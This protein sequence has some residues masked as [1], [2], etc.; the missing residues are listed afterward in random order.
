[1]RQPPR[2]QP[3]ARGIELQ[4]A[5]EGQFEQ[6]PPQDQP[7]AIQEAATKAAKKL[8]SPFPVAR[9]GASLLAFSTGRWGAEPVCEEAPQCADCPVWSS[10][11][12]VGVEAVDAA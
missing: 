8:P 7:A 2:Q 5:A 12:R 9:L 6:R 3:P 1:M 10:C 11:K 4:G